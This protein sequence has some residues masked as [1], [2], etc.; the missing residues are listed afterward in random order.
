[1]TIANAVHVNAS[2]L[3]VRLFARP[4]FLSVLVA[5][6]AILTVFPVQVLLG[7][8]PFWNNPRG[9]VGGSV[10]DMAAA[11]S[12]YYAYVR[13]VWRW[14]LFQ[15]AGIGPNGLNITLTDSIPI[16]ALAGRLL[17]LATGKII[18]L[19]GLWSGLCVG[20]MALAFT[21]LVRALGARSLVAAGAAAII[22]VSMPAFL[23]RWGHLALMAQALIPLALIV[24][25]RMRNTARLHAGAIVRQSL[26]LCLGSLLVHPYL[27]LMVAGIVVAAILQA[28]TDQRLPRL[29]AACILVA[30]ISAVACMMVAMGYVGSGVAPSDDGFGVY[31][32]NLLSLVAPSS[33]SLPGGTTF[34]IDGTGGQYEGMAFLGT[35]VIILAMLARRSILPTLAAAWRRHPWLL[36]VVAGFTALAV[37]NEVYL[38]SLHLLT[39][40]LP[41]G[42]LWAAGM[43]R[44]SGRF[45]WVAMYLLAALAIAAAARRKD[46]TLIL[47][48]AAAIQCARAEPL[49]HA[50]QDSVA[51]QPSSVLDRAAWQAI[52]PSVDQ[53][54]VD[55]P[56][57]C[58]PD[59]SWWARRTMAAVE[60]Q[61]LA[62]QSGVPT[63]TVYAARTVADCGVPQLTPRSILVRLNSN[64]P[65]PGLNCVIRPI[66]SVCTAGVQP[67]RLESLLPV[68]EVELFR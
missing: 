40:P 25:L 55:P 13:D 66:G 18:P 7:T 51:G 8:A 62:A 60:L 11:Q 67:G 1:M 46:A 17:F 41:A 14:P 36:A 33:G 35:G 30:L 32:A 37:S 53:V 6:A 10:A 4:W 34:T 58:L 50:I 20:G 2:G 39:V 47:I 59:G 26:M 28:G 56:A 16:I 52:L 43:F 23:A 21:G 3:P 15:V 31:S 61:L 44:T 38:G 68:G 29:H 24:Y 45:A 27:F 9:I 19:Y 22:G 54:V 5:S 42:V 57:A 64:S 48:L 49:R 65:A 63:N 12:G